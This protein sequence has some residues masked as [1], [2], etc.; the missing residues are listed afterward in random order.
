MCSATSRCG[1]VQEVSNLATYWARAQLPQII[2]L[3]RSPGERRERFRTI[4]VE[5]QAAGAR[6]PHRRHLASAKRNSLPDKVHEPIPARNPA[7]PPWRRCLVPSNSP[8]R[9]DRRVHLQFRFPPRLRDN[10]QGCCARP[11]GTFSCVFRLAR[12]RHAY[13]SLIQTLRLSTAARVCD[14]A[15]EICQRDKHRR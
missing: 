15:N 5:R 8:P 9:A 13:C 7:R 1:A 12:N 10:T 3:A 14:R 2:R 4:K 6:F 11:A